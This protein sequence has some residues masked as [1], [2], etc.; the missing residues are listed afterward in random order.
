MK[1]SD[2]RST[3]NPRMNPRAATRPHRLVIP[4]RPAYIRPSMRL[5]LAGILQLILFTGACFAQAVGDVESVGFEHVYRPGC[6]TPM[7]VRLNP[8]GATTFRGKI[9]VYQD[10][11][12]HDHPIFTRTIDLGG[13][14]EAGAAGADRTTRFWMYF[15]PQPR[16]D[17]DPKHNLRVYLT[18]EDG[19]Q[20]TRLPMND[21]LITVDDQSPSHGTKLVLTV[22]DQSRPIFAPYMR[23]D[24]IGLKETVY[25]IQVPISNV[26]H[27]LPES[28][29]GYE[30]VDA[31]V[32]CD[33]DP[34]RLSPAQRQALEEYVRRGG[35]LVV[36]QSTRANVWQ[37]VARPGEKGFGSLLPVDV[38][39]IGKADDI[40]PLKR[41]VDNASTAITF[42]ANRPKWKDIAAGPYDI[43][44]A[45]PKPLANVVE[46]EQPE[47]KGRPWLVRG[48]YGTGSVTW[49]AQDLGDPI[50]TSRAGVAGTE[51][52]SED[53]KWM[54][55]WDRVMDWANAS[56]PGNDKIVSQSYRIR[57]AGS[58]G[59]YPLGKNYLAGMEFGQR[60]AAYLSLAILLF[61]VYWVVAGPGSYIYL[62]TR[63]RTGTSW[64]AFALAAIVATVATAL[65]VKVVLRGPPEIH[66]VTFVRAAPGEPVVAH[67]MFGLYIPRDADERVSLKNPSKNATSF[68]TAFPT[69]TPTDEGAPPVEYRVPTDDPAAVTFPFR[70]TLKKM[71]ARYVGDEPFAITGAAAALPNGIDGKLVNKTGVTFKNIYVVWND[72]DNIRRDWVLYV[73][74]WK[75]DDTLDLKDKWSKSKKLPLSKS[76][77]ID[78]GQP[79]QGWIS[80]NGVAGWDVY[81]HEQLGLSAAENDTFVMPVNFPMLSLFD[82]LPP[83]SNN[84][85][86]GGTRTELRRNALR[87]LDV[88]P[89]LSAGQLVILA[90]AEDAGPLPAPVEVEGDIVGGDGQSYYQFILP[91]D[92]SALTAAPATQPAATTKESK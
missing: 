82:H 26:E 61:I 11:L 16:L 2:L 62:A 6:W 85:Q 32:W 64:F 89:A 39:D 24:P 41:I 69:I 31:V 4:S 12:D 10:D 52:A 35:K 9:A 23:G 13:K 45:Q 56:Q 78:P 20:V 67:A 54:Y 53:Y 21:Q 38:K 91:I 27:M 65:I 66:H 18:T 3:R 30:A 43:A 59:T 1:P 72:E 14:G 37:M 40:T 71:Q 68:V 83:M 76:G 49:V 42:E 63:K 73:P 81:W 55:V 29:L 75:K 19:K 25:P 88:T 44:E 87:D 5:F 50:L 90:Q 51:K 70:S 84:D 57:Y 8:T 22:V 79:C 47:R 7:V 86:A 28:V 15:I 33:A 80:K 92:R 77:G 74:E 60:S 58:T 46:Y 36:C 17:E 48:A 34:A